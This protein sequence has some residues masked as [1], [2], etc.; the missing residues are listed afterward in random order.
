MQ[1]EAIKR[2]IAI[3]YRA[4]G[5]AEKLHREGFIRRGD[6]VRETR[7]RILSLETENYQEF[8]ITSIL[9]R[10]EVLQRMLDKAHYDSGERKYYP[11]RG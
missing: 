8:V 4:R 11:T 10:A 2:A 6:S 5:F 7:E 3:A 9:E 1:E